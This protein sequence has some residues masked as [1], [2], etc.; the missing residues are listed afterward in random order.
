MA[1]QKKQN[2]MDPRQREL[3]ELIELK[4]MKQAAAEHQDVEPLF[5]EEEKIVPKTFRDKWKNYWYHYKAATWIT[6][7]VVIAA[8][9]MIKDIFFGPEYDLTV[10]T[11]TKYTFSALNNDLQ[12]D[13]GRY[14]QQDYNGDGEQNVSYSE[15]SVDFRE[16]S[17]VDPQMN[18]IN[19]QKFMAVF[20]SGSDL[21]F[22][23]DQEAY[24]T[25]I[26][27]SGDG[28]FVNLEEIY[29]D[30][31]IE[32]I[33]GDKFII[34]DTELGKDMF[35]DKIGEDVFI[36]LRGFGGTADPDKKEVQQA[37]Q[38]GLD[39]IDNLLRETYPDKMAEN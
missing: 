19:M 36:C 18:A 23:M 11:A 6:V 28:L 21:L 29:G 31:G 3:Q 30:L 34:N 13:M 9:W 39:F 1:K 5:P 16:D 4:K 25:I 17:T 35:L 38:A 37:Y 12:E 7:C 14:V 33:Q 20:A 2:S 27:N 22:I 15:I 10:T 24:D 32:E 8:G 26:Q